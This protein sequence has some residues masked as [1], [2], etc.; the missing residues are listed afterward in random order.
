[1]MTG[2][3]WFVSRKQQICYRHFA[4]EMLCVYS[5]APYREKSWICLL[6]VD[7]LRSPSFACRCGWQL[8]KTKE[9]KIKW[10]SQL[11]DCHA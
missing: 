5:T 2:K 8:P 6:L 1:M 4:V 11:R 9:A 10:N 7:Q 3:V